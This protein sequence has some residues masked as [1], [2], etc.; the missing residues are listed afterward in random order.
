MRYLTDLE[1]AEHAWTA[2]EIRMISARQREMRRKWAIRRTLPYV[3]VGIMALL[4]IGLAILI[5]VNL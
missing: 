2:R 4:V 1:E 5:E 3:G